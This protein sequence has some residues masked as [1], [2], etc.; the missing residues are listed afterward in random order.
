LNLL[1]KDKYYY[2]YFE[3]IHI[4]S[5][6]FYNDNNWRIL[7]LNKKFIHTKYEEKDL[8]KILDDNLK[9]KKK[10]LIIF[11]DC[12]AEKIRQ[13]NTKQNILDAAMMNTRH[14]NCSFILDAQ[15]VTSLSIA[16]RQNCD[17]AVIFEELNENEIKALYRDFGR[18]KYQK[19][20]EILEFATQ[21]NYSFLFVH[22]QGP[23]QTYYKKFFKRIN[24]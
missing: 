13:G 17:G 23:K 10:M 18:G 9:N 4:F 7:K 8:K 1:L 2:K 16:T 24:G 12:G 5:P 19:F 22:R 21:D 6:T 14:Y 20:L 3:I 15:C 11:S